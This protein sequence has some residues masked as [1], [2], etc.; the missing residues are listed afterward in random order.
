MK[1][2]KNTIGFIPQLKIAA[3]IDVHKNKMVVCILK[4][5]GEE[6]LEE[7]GTTTRQ[8]YKLKEFL[9]KHS[10]KDCLMESTGIYWYGL[11]NILEQA[12][13]R[14]V[15]E[16]PY[17]IKQMPME[18]TD[19]KDSRW[20]CRLLINGMVRGSFIPPKDQRE[21]RDLCRMRLKY[22]QHMSRIK[23]RMVKILEMNNIKLRSVVSN[24]S[25][26]TAMNIIRALVQGETD[27]QKLKELCRGKL[28]KKME[29]MPE[30]LEGTLGAH[31]RSI[32]Q[33]LLD[34]LDFYHLRLRDLEQMIDD[35]M[36]KFE[37]ESEKLQQIRGIAEKSAE[38]IIAEIGTD[39]SR[40]PTPD[41]LTNWSG[42]APGL[43][44]TA[45][46][47]KPVGRKPGNQYITTAMIQVAWVA[48]RMK[49][50]YWQAV[51][52]NLIRKLPKGKAIV[53]IARKLI[54]LIHK[55]L[56]GEIIYKELS[57][58]DYFNKIWERRLL[59]RQS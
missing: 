50:S 47:R 15:I 40:F 7:F 10:V 58:D 45:D 31:E 29:L 8:L 18:K 9:I 28:R 39:M 41:H 49:G 22:T 6:I 37:K 54:R 46:K 4:A 30:A 33:M 11:Y 1:K 35:H 16:N 56:S 17:R 24:L 14:V 44:E 5:N 25:T 32:L 26:K 59:L 12:G 21:L 27:P 19:K 51:Y 3:G 13:L 34:E 36:K 42:V 52:K 2:K 48:V 23:N 43:R 53:A 38:T 20:L 55:I 57:A